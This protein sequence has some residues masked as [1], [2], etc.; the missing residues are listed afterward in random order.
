ML[1]A[2][3]VLSINPVTVRITAR[4]SPAKRASYTVAHYILLTSN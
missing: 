1:R 2:S 4:L 3:N